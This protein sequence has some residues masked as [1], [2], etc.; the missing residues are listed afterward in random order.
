[1]MIECWQEESEHNANRVVELLV[2]LPRSTREQARSHETFHSP[3]STTELGPEEI[4][5]SVHPRAA[6]TTT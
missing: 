5:R 1:M 4:R 6:L 2:N 3:Y